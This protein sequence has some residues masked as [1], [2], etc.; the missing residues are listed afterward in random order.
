MLCLVYHANS[1]FECGLDLRISRTLGDVC[2]GWGLGSVEQSSSALN[3]IFG[4]NNTVD[5]YYYSM[6][7]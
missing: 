6:A 7:C 5:Y 2:V 4:N 1:R 3:F